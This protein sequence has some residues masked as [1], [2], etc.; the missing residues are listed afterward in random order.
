MYL[1]RSDA[2]SAN[3]VTR[4]CATRISILV[5]YYV[6]TVED[7]SINVCTG[8]APYEEVFA[9]IPGDIGRLH[10]IKVQGKGI[11]FVNEMT[12]RSFFLL[13]KQKKTA[14][15]STGMGGHLQRSNEGSSRRRAF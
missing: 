8:P 14:V 12:G 4:S 13:H 9:A 11:L 6:Q 7:S 15:P 5:F 2:L 1:V 3:P 10:V